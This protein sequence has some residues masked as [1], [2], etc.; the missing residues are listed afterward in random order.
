MRCD[1]CRHWKSRDE[2]DL[3][4]SGSGFRECLAVRERW[5]IQDEASESVKWDDDEDS[6]YAKRRRDAIA[7]ARAYLKD[8]TQFDA[9][10]FTG[11]DFFCALF[12]K[13]D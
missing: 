7:A 3:E 6:A 12:G 10:L 4:A 9:K 13:A 11:P 5:V 8:G 2:Q 1:Q